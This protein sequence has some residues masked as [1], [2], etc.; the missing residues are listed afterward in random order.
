MN[1]DYKYMIT[2]LFYPRPHKLQI[3]KISTEKF[4]MYIAQFLHVRKTGRL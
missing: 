1:T 4:F 3:A 2:L